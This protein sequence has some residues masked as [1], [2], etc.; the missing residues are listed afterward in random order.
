M[1]IMMR[2]LEKEHAPEWEMAI[3]SQ[4]CMLVSNL[5]HDELFCKRMF[6]KY[7]MIEVAN[8]LLKK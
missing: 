5:S 2:L 1:E 6:Q 8:N 3:I 4:T 7:D